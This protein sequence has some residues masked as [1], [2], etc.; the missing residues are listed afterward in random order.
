[1]EAIQA[2]RIPLTTANLG[3]DSCNDDGTAPFRAPAAVGMQ[4]PPAFTVLRQCVVIED[5]SKTPMED[6]L[7]EITGQPGATSSLRPSSY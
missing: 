2:T 3:W 5:M 1:M 4:T 6:V 7:A